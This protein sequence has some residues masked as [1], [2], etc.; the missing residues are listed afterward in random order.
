MGHRV[1]VIIIAG[2]CTVFVA[3]S[4]RYSYGILL[5]EMLPALAI[6]KTEAGIIFSS[7]FL[8]CTLCSPILGLL[9]DR[10][11]ARALLTIFVAILGM[12]AYL[13]S[14]ST[15][16][17]QASIFFALAGI[18]HSACWS[19]F[20]TVVMRWV[21][22]K[23]RG[24]ALSIVDLGSTVGI[25]FWSFIIPIMIGPYSWRT[26]WVWLGISAF[27]AAGMNFFSVK[28]Q[29]PTEREPQGSVGASKIRIPIKTAY[30]AIFRDK[31][32]YLIG[33]SYLFISFSILIP[34]TF[35]TTYATQALKIPYQSAA[36]LVAFI[37]IAGAIGKIPLAHLS[38]RVGRVKVMILCGVLTGAGGLGMAYAPGFGFLS[39]STVVFGVGYGTIWAVYAASARDLFSPD[40]SGSI[41]GLWTVYHGIGSV[42]APVFAGWTIDATG[43]YVWAF[44]MAV[45][46]SALSMLVLLP[47]LKTAAVEIGES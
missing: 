38:D 27:L 1:V 29:P 15:T 10:W 47:L 42:L 30:K 43:T 18:G 46:S 24:V 41:V 4:I 34:F 11:N 17:L 45:I 14:F 35:L 7:Y 9:V 37:G 33:S 2:F 6:S 25:A 21:S 19:P 32:F 40:Y 8:I 44:I 3:F 23:R 5:P 12:G 13:M 36:G 31:K 16:V 22:D 39:V 20:V 26:V 28:N